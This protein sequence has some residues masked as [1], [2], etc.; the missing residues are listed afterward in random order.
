MA[1]VAILVEVSFSPDSF[2]NK[3]YAIL[4][5]ASALCG[6]VHAVQYQ[7]DATNSHSSVTLVNSVFVGDQSDI[8]TI[9][10]N[11]PFFSLKSDTSLLD[12]LSLSSAN[13]SALFRCVYATNAGN[14][15]FHQMPEPWP[16]LVD[17]SLVVSL[18]ANGRANDGTYSDAHDITHMVSAGFAFNLSAVGT[19][20]WKL[21]PDPASHAEY[22][23]M[24]IRVSVWANYSIGASGS[25]ASST[26]TN[27][28][29]DL[30]INDG[31]I[32]SFYAYS[33][34]N[35]AEFHFNRWLGPNPLNGESFLMPLGDDLK[36]SY[37]FESHMQKAILPEGFWAPESFWANEKDTDLYVCVKAAKDNLIW[38]VD[39]AGYMAKLNGALPEPPNLPEMENHLLQ[40]VPR[41]I[42][43]REIILAIPLDTLRIPS[44]LGLKNSH[45]HIQ[46]SIIDPQ[47]GFLVP[48]GK[49]EIADGYDD[50]PR[51][52]DDIF[53]QTWILTG[54]SSAEPPTSKVEFEVLID[55]NNDTVLDWRFI[56][57]ID[58]QTVA[59][60]L[61]DY[62]SDKWL[63]KVK[64]NK[65]T[66]ESELVC[67]PQWSRFTVR[68]TVA[69]EIILD[70]KSIEIESKS[71]PA[72]LWT[73][74][75]HAVQTPIPNVGVQFQVLRNPALQSELFRAKV[76]LPSV[77]H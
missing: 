10:T 39:K 53:L 62:D 30:S 42:G 77:L 14:V 38:C 16:P 63:C 71:S 72:E 5:A 57:R 24:P 64:F 69:G 17:M 23:G 15:V 65:E 2:M 46:V 12:P 8:N 74:V 13:Q 19:L 25:N 22:L 66:Q 50:G 68:V 21:M 43:Y 26:G 29:L 58:V 36:L 27:G 52:V 35:P 44:L 70:L 18:D 48:K 76:V 40:Q 60:E 31:L 6:V 55:T 4:V 1:W 54:S 32:G 56:E 59:V 47:Y 73:P 3:P 9:H 28:I 11:S 20:K 34:T 75:T 67:D 41:S 45:G 33:V 7:L 37:R 51:I 61:I 49:D